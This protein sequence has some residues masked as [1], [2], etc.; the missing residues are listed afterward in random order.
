MRP[1]GNETGVNSIDPPARP[2]AEGFSFEPP[3]RQGAP[4]LPDRRSGNGPAGGGV[5]RDDHPDFERDRPRGNDRVSIRRPAPWRPRGLGT[6]LLIDRTWPA[7]F[8]TTAVFGVCVF[9]FVS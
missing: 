1:A 3:H 5:E 8:V 7:R 4:S 9:S 2:A 6:A